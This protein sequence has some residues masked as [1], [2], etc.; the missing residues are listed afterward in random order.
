MTSEIDVTNSLNKNHSNAFFSKR[1]KTGGSDQ[2]LEF[3]TSHSTI[4]IGIEENIFDYVPCLYACFL[5]TIFIKLKYFHKKTGIYT[6]KILFILSFISRLIFISFEKIMFCFIYNIHT[7]IKILT[8][9][10][11]VWVFIHLSHAWK[12]TA[13]HLFLS[14]LVKRAQCS[15][16]LV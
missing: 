6:R 10:L 9:K 14:F 1:C 15:T 11:E 12:K 3:S 2:P 16:K 13:K 5:M 4:L 7:C 8:W